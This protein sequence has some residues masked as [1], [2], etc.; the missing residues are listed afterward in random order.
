MQRREDRLPGDLI[1]WGANGSGRGL[2][3]EWR[4]F[5]GMQ[6]LEFDNGEPPPPQ[7]V[8]G[9]EIGGFLITPE[10]QDAI[11]EFT[12]PSFPDMHGRRALAL[13]RDEMQ[14]DGKLIRV[15]KDSG[16]AVE[17]AHGAGYNAMMGLPHDAVPPVETA[18]RMVEFLNP[19]ASEEHRA[20]SKVAMRR[21]ALEER[22]QQERGVSATIA[23]VPG[24]RESIHLVEHGTD[25]LFG[26][27]AEHDRKPSA[28]DWAVLFLNAGAV[29]HTGPNR[30][31]VDAA[32]RWA[33]RGVR[34]LRLD[35]EGVGESD[36]IETPGTP[37]LYQ[38][39]LV[40]QVE[41]AMDSLRSRFGIRNFAAVGLCAGH[42]GG[43]TP[44]RVR[45]ISGRL[46]C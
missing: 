15:L 41:L 26:V 22:G 30:M 6:R 8:P 29:R 7:P 11:Q 16:C 35:L 45:R 24:V 10:T 21:T 38:D 20:C 23:A 25:T 36:G 42:F 44:R 17:I 14:P 9:L 3:R 31:W 4:A 37:G 43:S 33:A 32:R 39:R 28:T 12:L 34:S 5:A 19:P 13:S 1:L 40:D 46:C 27:L 18:V 2:L